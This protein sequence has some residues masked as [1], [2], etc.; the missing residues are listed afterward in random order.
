MSAQAH[1]LDEY[2]QGTLISVEKNRVQAEITLTP[3]VAVFPILLAEIDTNGDGVI[4][5]S[6]Q[7]KYATRVLRDLSLRIDGR[8][9]TPQL[10]STQFATVGQMKD[11]LGEIRIKI[12]AD[13]PSGGANRRIVF[14]NHHYNRIAAYQ[15]NCLVPRDPDIRIAA[16]KR[17][18][19]QSV[20][21][22]EYVQAG[23]SSVSGAGWLGAIALALLLRF[24]YLS[25]RHQHEALDG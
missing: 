25:T 22:L 10:L 13:L 6:E 12:A 9:L 16:Q 11:G 19:L 5:D 7:R 15:V 20:Y 2:L 18:Y 21:E 23:V 3:G 24:A 17:N 1:R 4:S 8:P 14:E